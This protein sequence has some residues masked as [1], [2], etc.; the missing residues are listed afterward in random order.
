[1]NATESCLCVF[2]CNGFSVLNSFY[3]V[4]TETLIGDHVYTSALSVNNMYLFIYCTLSS[5]LVVFDLV[6]FCL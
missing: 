6:M 3:F 1:M 2:L 4:F 5:T